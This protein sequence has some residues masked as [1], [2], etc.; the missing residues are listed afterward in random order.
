MAEQAKNGPSKLHLCVSG[1]ASTD[2]QA[3]KSAQSYLDIQSFSCSG[4][5]NQLSSSAGDGY[6]KAQ[7][8][9]GAHQTAACK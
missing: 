1:G 3:A 2:A 8:T 9:Y 4:L 5:I 7:A 6:T